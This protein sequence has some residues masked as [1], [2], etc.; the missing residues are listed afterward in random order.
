MC[1]PGSLVPA[2]LQRS[3]A[4]ARFGKGQGMLLVMLLQRAG[5]VTAHEV[6]E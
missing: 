3:A 6:E 4:A 1:D 2:S 5:R